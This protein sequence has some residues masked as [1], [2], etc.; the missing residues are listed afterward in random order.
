M[1]IDKTLYQYRKHEGS[2][3]ETRRKQVGDQLT[4]LR[5]CYLGRIFD[6]LLIG[7]TCF[8]VCITK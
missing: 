5:I 6:A 3:S 1:P 8:V 2:L 7:K 4:K